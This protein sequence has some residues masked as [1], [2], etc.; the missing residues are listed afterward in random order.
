[1]NEEK[2][3]NKTVAEPVVG[4]K[5]RNA[6]V[7]YIAVMFAVAFALVALSYLIQMK[8]KRYFLIFSENITG[9]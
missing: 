2:E 7:R 4:E 6:M 3:T 1:M 5:K 8:K 9:S